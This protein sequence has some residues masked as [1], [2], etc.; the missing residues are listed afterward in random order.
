MHQL[1]SLCFLRWARPAPVDPPGGDVSYVVLTAGLTPV[2]IIGC[3][4][5]SPIK[6]YIKDTQSPYPIYT[7]PSLSLYKLF[8]FGSKMSGDGE[9]EYIKEAGSSFKRTMDG[10][11][12]G[13]S[14][15]EHVMDAGPKGQNGGEM[16]LEEGR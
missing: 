15:M 9:R 13:L 10:V 5:S 6:T 12:G 1:Q 4:N 2:I 7:N 11:M 8:G 14:H 16:V 3:G